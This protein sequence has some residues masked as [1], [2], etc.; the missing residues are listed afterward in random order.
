MR[1][2][3]FIATAGFTDGIISILK[4]GIMMLSRTLLVAAA[5]MQSAAYTQ[6]LQPNQWIADGEVVTMTSIGDTIYLGGQFYYVGPVTSKNGAALDLING[7]PNS[8]FPTV[9]GVVNTAIADG[10]GGWFIGGN[11][12]SVGISL[13]DNLA[14]I[15]ADGSVHTWNPGVDGPVNALVLS[16]DTLFV[17]GLFGII[18]GEP[19]NNLAALDATTGAIDPAWDPNPLVK[20]ILNTTTS[21]WPGTRESVITLFLN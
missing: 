2:Q 1:P 21:R 16:G 13:R 12:T 18:N 10:A 7:D 5:V 14:R 17:G 8:L 20:L 6:T 11:F 3:M 15:N 4:R 9:S 19:R